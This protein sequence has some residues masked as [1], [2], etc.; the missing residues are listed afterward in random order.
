MEK[1]YNH[2]QNNVFALIGFIGGIFCSIADY[3]LEYLGQPSETLGLYGVVESAWADM[4]L[5]R[6][7]ASIWIVCI[8]VPMYLL[9]YLP[10][11]DRCIPLTKIWVQHLAYPP[12]SG[13]SGHCLFTLFYV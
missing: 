12:H 11:L 5:W 1:N 4:A 3:L 9:G 7:P 10:F 8:A 6:F 13:C 2:H